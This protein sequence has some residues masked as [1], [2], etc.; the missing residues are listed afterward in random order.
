[1]GAG[2]GFALNVFL[3]DGED[4]YRTYTTTGRGVERLGSNW[5]LLDLTPYG[6]QEQ[7]EDSPEGRPQS[8]P[9]QWWRL[10][11]EYGS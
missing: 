9:Y 5:T 2:D 8:A 1:M 11:D 4:V 3:R 10:H 6:R 7:W